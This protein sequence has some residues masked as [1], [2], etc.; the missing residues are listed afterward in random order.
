[1]TT[2]INIVN[3]SIHE[4]I[5]RF[6]RISGFYDVVTVDDCEIVDAD[7]RLILKTVLDFLEDKA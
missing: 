4:L 7:Y 6:Y 5:E 3:S 1:M 2:G